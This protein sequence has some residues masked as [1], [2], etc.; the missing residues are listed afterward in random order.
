ML[1]LAEIIN[2]PPILSEKIVELDPHEMFMRSKIEHSKLEFNQ[3]QEWISHDLHRQLKS[4][5]HQS[6]S[7][8]SV[9]P[10]NQLI[11]TT[12]LESVDDLAFNY[13]TLSGF[14]SNWNDNNNKTLGN[15]SISKRIQVLSPLK[16]YKRSNS[17]HS[18]TCSLTDLSEVKPSHHLFSTNRE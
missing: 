2:M 18:S 15:A 16:R 1:V 3:Y 10:N 17:L 14:E 7:S 6:L 8:V 13:L 11:E 12:I 5:D 9:L 4:L